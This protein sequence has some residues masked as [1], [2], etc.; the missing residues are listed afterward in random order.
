MK[1]GMQIRGLLFGNWGRRC[2]G[3]RVFSR[4]L[5]W[6][7]WSFRERGRIRFKLSKNREG[8]SNWWPFSQKIEILLFIFFFMFLYWR[9]I[10]EKSL[11]DVK[12]IKIVRSIKKYLIMFE[13]ILWESWRFIGIFDG[14]GGNFRRKFWSL[15]GSS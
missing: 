7:N 4:F 2:K 10:F 13:H 11:R 6:I 8:K 5:L 15:K 14:L 9:G 1:Q 12:I 3:N